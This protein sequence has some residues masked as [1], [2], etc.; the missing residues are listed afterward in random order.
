MGKKNKKTSEAD[1]NRGL[2]SKI[3]GPGKEAQDMLKRYGVEGY[4]GGG[5]AIEMTGKS[6]RGV[7]EV[8]EDLANAMM[9]DYDTRRTMEAQAMAGNKDAKKFAKKGFKN[10]FYLQIKLIRLGHK[11]LNQLL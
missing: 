5:R 10:I 4:R 6:Y 9:K 8:K 3:Y 7:D 11:S 2:M 1:F